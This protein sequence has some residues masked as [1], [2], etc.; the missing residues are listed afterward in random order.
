VIHADLFNVGDRARSSGS[1]AVLVIRGVEIRQGTA[2]YRV[3]APAMGT[4]W[5]TQDELRP[6]PQRQGTG[7]HRP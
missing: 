3:E 5:V 2:W 6:A 1:A 4:W 7:D